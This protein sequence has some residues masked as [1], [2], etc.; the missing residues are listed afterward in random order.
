MANQADLTIEKVPQNNL[1]NQQGHHA[2]QQQQQQQHVAALCQQ[3][4]NTAGLPFTLM[5]SLCQIYTAAA[6][7]QPASASPNNNQLQELEAEATLLGLINDDRQ[8]ALQV[9]L[10]TGISGRGRQHAM[11]TV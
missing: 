9:P 3:P 5:T 6:A 8:T 4:G 10:S 1:S 2:E 7:L 11:I